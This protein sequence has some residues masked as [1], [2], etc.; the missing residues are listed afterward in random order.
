M[1]YSE[2]ISASSLHKGFPGMSVGAQWCIYQHIVMQ[3]TL[4]CWSAPV[5]VAGQNA[6]SIILHEASLGPGWVVPCKKTYLGA[7]TSFIRASSGFFFAE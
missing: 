5:L 7:Y 3:T 2:Y 4:P 1:L 6:I